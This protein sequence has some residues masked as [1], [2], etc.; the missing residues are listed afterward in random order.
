ML[1]EHLICKTHP[2]ANEK[3]V[4]LWQDYRVTVLGERLFR[5][6]KSAEKIFEQG[7]RRG[8]FF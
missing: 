7:G 4:V 6:E 5:I 3:N 2:E 8:E 1:N